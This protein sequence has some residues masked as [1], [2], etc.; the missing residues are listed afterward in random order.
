VKVLLVADIV[1]G[2]RTFMHSLARELVNHGVELHLALIGEDPQREFEALGTRSCEVR[3]LRLEWMERPWADVQ[4][5]AD[6]VE[7]LRGA[8]QPDLV[9]MNTFAPVLD[10]SVPVLLSAHSCVASWWRGVHDTD[11]PRSWDRYRRL[12]RSALDRAL[13][14]AAPT[15]ALVDQLRAVYGVLPPTRVIPNGVEP[16]LDSL[17]RRPPE[18]LVVCAGRLWDSAKNVELVAR[19]APQL[20]GRVVLIGPGGVSGPN[21][22]SVGPV[23]Q[24]EVLGW[25]QR[26][27]VFAEPARYE[28]FGL[29]ALEAALCGCALV[30][31]DIASLREV[32]GGAATFVSPDDPDGLTAAVNALLR[33]R[34]LREHAAGAARERASQ[35]TAARMS[36]AYLRA[37][38][39]VT[40]EA[41]AA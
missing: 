24:T 25:L 39:E 19:A 32:W 9:H 7:S 17:P 37:Y 27:A 10:P 31:G 33:D 41:V 8:H 29:A 20:R 23:A 22:E 35:Y 4:A 28:P 26:A 38:S 11:P 34:D 5:T 13:T 16:P 2:V 1:G 3:D 6:W 14:L 15:Q 30:L 18:Q 21:L 12:V 36:A 40:A